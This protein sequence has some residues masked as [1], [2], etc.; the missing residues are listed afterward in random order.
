MRFWWLSVVLLCGG[1]AHWSFPL[2]LPGAKPDKVDM[3][4]PIPA[5]NGEVLKPQRTVSELMLQRLALCQD[6]DVTQRVSSASVESLGAVAEG[7]ADEAR[8]TALL[9][10]SCQP[11]KTPGVFNQLLADLTGAGTWPAEYA[12]F[13]ELLI[14]NQRAYALV[15]KL[16]LELKDEH[17]RVV[18]DYQ[19]TIQGLSEIEADIEFHNSLGHP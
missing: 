7:Q 9:K 14:A 5:E 6:P 11:A 17:E 18:L 13:F 1:C 16:Y 15:E 4:V 3:R 19:Q 8:L 2:A 12:A 10:A